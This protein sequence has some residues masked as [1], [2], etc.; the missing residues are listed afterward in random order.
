[1]SMRLSTSSNI[2]EYTLRNMTQFTYSCPESLRMIKEAGFG[3]ADICFCTFCR[4]VYPMTQP[5]WQ[6]WVNELKDTAA[7]IGLPISQSHAHF[8]DLDRS[9][10]FE[11]DEELVLRSIKAAGMMGIPWITLHPYSVKDEVGYSH[12]KSLEVNHEMFSRYGEW[13]AKEGVGI[14]IENMIER[15]NGERRFASGVE[16]LVEL[17]D[18]MNDSKLFGI[19]WDTGHAHLSRL[20]QP[21]A[22]K[23]VGKRLKA[24]HVADNKGEKDDHV[25]PYQGTIPWAPIMQTLKEIEYE[26]DF[27]YE[28]HEFGNPLPAGLRKQALVF[29]RE[30]G[31]Y[32]LSL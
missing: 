11:W 24:M 8:Y 13:A 9:E 19:C 23:I 28:V 1:M 26:G 21:A 15:R 3:A 7:E 10:N 30:T 17:V 2:C 29:A 18:S 6:D 22:L 32:L 5:N 27:T 12:K 14:A 16:E 25:L 20:D 31:E 4:G